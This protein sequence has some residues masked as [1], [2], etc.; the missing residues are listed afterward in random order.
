MWKR[1]LLVLLIIP[2]I[3]AL[4]LV[5]V[6]D[7]LGW[8]LTVALVVLTALLGMLFVRAEGRATLRRI[9]EKV[10]TGEPPTDELLDGGLLIA[11][12]A[13][14]LTPGLVTD[15]IGFLLVFPPTR[16][17]VRAGVKRWV[18]VPALDRRS[19]GFVTGRVYPAGFPDG[20]DD[21]PWA[22]STEGEPIDIDSS[23]VVEDDDEAHGG[24]RDPD[25][26]PDG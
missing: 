3:D 24:D 26:N 16:F 23:T 22:G 6:A 15:G 4:F 2:L 8:Q 25:R 11:A 5:V 10:A 7:F 12:G 20:T 1:I 14:L 9:Q 19:G 17:L 21:G 13:F 18:V